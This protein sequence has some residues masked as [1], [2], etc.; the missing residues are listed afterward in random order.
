MVTAMVWEGWMRPSDSLRKPFGNVD[1]ATP[2]SRKVPPCRP[3]NEP[4]SP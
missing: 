4:A 2:S 3:G 1:M